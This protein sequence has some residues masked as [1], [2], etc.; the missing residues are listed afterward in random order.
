MYRL[1]GGCRGANAAVCLVQHLI[2][3]TGEAYAGYAWRIRCCRQ[4]MFFWSTT[5]GFFDWHKRENPVSIRSSRN[6]HA[7]S[8]RNAG[9]VSGGPR[10]VYMLCP[11]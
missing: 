11:C 3:L 8:S 1:K 5:L 10:V 9:C 6:A 7:P 2:S 4:E